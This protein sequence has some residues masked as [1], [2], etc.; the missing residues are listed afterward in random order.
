VSWSP[1]DINITRRINS[2][3]FND[4]NIQIEQR[5]AIFEKADGKIITEESLK[6]SKLV[7]KIDSACEEIVSHILAITQNQIPISFLEFIMKLDQ[8]NRLWL[9]CC[10]RIKIKNGDAANLNTSTDTISL[11]RSMISNRSSFSQQQ[12]KLLFSEAIKKGK[13]KS[14]S[15]GKGGILREQKKD[16]SIAKN[17]IFM[18]PRVR[19]NDSL[20]IVK[21]PFST[22]KKSTRVNSRSKFTPRRSPKL[23]KYTPKISSR[24]S[25]RTNSRLS[26]R[27]SKKGE[28]SRSKSLASMSRTRSMRSTNLSNISKKSHLKEKSIKNSKMNTKMGRLLGFVRN[29]ISGNMIK[30]PPLLVRNISYRKNNASTSK[31]HSIERRGVGEIKMNRDK[32]RSKLKSKA[33]PKPQLGKQK[34]I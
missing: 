7:D 34:S 8:D 9:L 15:R 23:P 14:R 20:K 17:R 3:R 2:H 21:I 10:S 5:L 29:A 1:V 11:M 25:S 27:S 24:L 19:I 16:K 4:S 32:S 22:R 12:K 33:K 31:K 26:K 30:S 13:K 6:E 18:S 28:R